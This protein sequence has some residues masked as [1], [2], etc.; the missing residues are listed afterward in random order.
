MD[1][2]W[3]HRGCLV[4]PPPPFSILPA[5]QA[6]KP[7]P[8]GTHLAFALSFALFT[9]SPSSFAAEDNA[10]DRKKIEANVAAYTKAY[11]EKDAAA[12]AAF[13]SESG[14][15]VS[16]TSGET[17]SGRKAIENQYAEMFADAGDSALE[18]DVESVRFITDDVAVEEGIAKV[19]Y[20]GELPS[21][22]R[23][24]V[25]HIKQ[26]GKWLIDSIR[27]TVLPPAAADVE[28]NPASASGGKMEAL[29][30]MIG[31]WIDGGDGSA[32]Y[33]SCSWGMGNK[34][35]KREFS[36]AIEDRVEMDG[37]EVI[38]WDPSEEIYRSWVFDSEGGFGSAT[39][40]RDGDTWIKRMT[41]TT[42]SGKKAFAA[43][44]IEKI[45]DDSYRFSSH[46]R[47]LDGQLLP[48]IDAVT[49]VRQKGEK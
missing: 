23:Y 10:D 24:R 34:F 37:I 42:S 43:H 7:S 15:F 11:Q 29:G 17:V 47:E 21:E 40:T 2:S 9:I 38:G 19:I 20:P 41:G 18:V 49:V 30:W 8:P 36:V 4:V 33:F 12:L 16:P 3:C 27:E 46:G 14:Q 5:T 45:D 13:W 39:W 31:D 32:I 48:N 35:I 1:A 26:D 25:I 22:S 28:E 6:M 44:R